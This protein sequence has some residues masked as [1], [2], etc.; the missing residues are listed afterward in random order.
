MYVSV[1]VKK[2]TK[3]KWQNITNTLYE[4]NRYPK[5]DLKFQELLL[6]SLV[7]NFS[8]VFLQV[9]LIFPYI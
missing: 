7:F 5:I 4:M 2:S 1:F 8:A 9:R 3:T 6:I